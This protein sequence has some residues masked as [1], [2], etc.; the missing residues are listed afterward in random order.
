MAYNDDALTQRLSTLNDSQESIEA[1]SS[2]MAFHRRH[3]DRLAQLW[4]TRLRA[5][6]SPKCLA[7]LYLCNHIVQNAIHRKRPEFPN[8]FSPLMPEAV[9]VAYKVSPKDIQLKIQRLVDVW[10]QRK[11]FPDDILQATRDRIN[12][13]EKTKGGGGKKLMG[14][15][16]FSSSSGVPKELEPL[17]SYQIASSKLDF[18]V[19]P[20]VETAMEEH[21]K[22]KNPSTPPPSAPVHAANL[23]SLIKKLAIAEAGLN[24]K[25]KARKAYI[26]ELHRLVKEAELVLESD[27]TVQLN[28]SA[29]RTK[30][31]TKKRDVEDSIMRGLTSTPNEMEEDFVED[32]RPDVE[33][34]TPEPDEMP[35]PPPAETT[36]SP[37]P[38]AE[39]RN[40]NLQ[41]ILAGFGSAG[42]TTATM[43]TDIPD[44]P[45]DY[46]SI[47]ATN[48]N[49]AN[50]ASISTPP[51]PGPPS[52]KKRKL[53]HDLYTAAAVPDLGEMGVTG[54]DGTSDAPTPAAPGTA[55]VNPSAAGYHTLPA[56][57]SNL[58]ANTNANSDMPSA[59]AM[60]APSLDFLEEDVDALI[61]DGRG[62][63]PVAAA[64]AGVGPDS[65]TETAR[66]VG[67]DPPI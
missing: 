39:A 28:I 40:P 29:E 6:P 18:A 35:A 57:A 44:S 26:E 30:A 7:F 36:L 37:P 23:S 50:G 54:Y 24:D 22:F 34:L 47:P 61:R 49:P 13:V 52:S 42:D 12:D 19:M 38:Q 32:R 67:D 59:S 56:G 11:V 17:V 63:D 16:L 8:A 4:L 64:G 58:T 46:A 2:W 53:S 10:K 41:G 62:V 27:Q 20:N 14:K 25:I 3:A 15:S 43:P 33:E 9:Q 48:I 60:E 66:T 45:L 21:S 5:T 55:Y 51:L 31:E 65:S 1:I